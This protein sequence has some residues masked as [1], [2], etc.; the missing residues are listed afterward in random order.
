MVAGSVYPAHCENDNHKIIGE[1]IDMKK[2]VQTSLVIAMMLIGVG[3]ASAMG[4]KDLA[5][6]IA[7]QVGISTEQAA[8]AV[9]AFK[10]AV[11]A[12]VKTGEAVRLRGFG[13]F[14]MKESKAHKGHNP[15]T[16]KVIDIP[17]RNHLRFKAF[18]AAKDAIN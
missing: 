2:I 15:R 11:I 17:A 13:K 5:K 18:Q 1:Q 16:G 10:A 9:E 14:T 3:S 8:A 6:V 12:Q 7:K 4:D